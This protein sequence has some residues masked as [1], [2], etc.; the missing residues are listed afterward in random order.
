MYSVAT[1]KNSINAILEVRGLHFNGNNQG[2]ANLDTICTVNAVGLTKVDDVFQPHTTSIIL[3]HLI[4][5]NLGMEHDQSNCD[6]SKGP[7]CIMTNNIPYFTSTTFSGC[8]IQK[9]FKTLNQGY[10]ACLFNM[11]TLRMS[12]CGNSILEEPEECDCGPPEECAKHDPCCDPVTCRLI[13]HAEC[14]SG[15]CCKKCK[16]LSSDHLCRTSEGECDIPEYCDGKNGQCPDDLF[17]KNGA[18]CSGGLGY[19]FQ[20]QCPLLKTQCQNVWGEDAENANAA[21][22]ERLNIL[23]T[24]NGNCGYDN[25]GDIRKCATEDSYCG[26]LQCSE[27]EKE[28]VSKDVLPMDFVVYKMNTD[29]SVHECKTRTF[30]STDLKYGLVKDGTK[31]GYQKLCLNQTCTSIRSIISGK[32]PLEEIHSTCSGHGICTNINTCNCEEGW[33]GHD[34]SIIDEDNQLGNA[35]NDAD[36][37]DS[38]ENELRLNPNLAV[39]VLAGCIFI[40]LVLVVI[41]VLFLFNRNLWTAKSATH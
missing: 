16:L 6:C 23:G 9:Y 24:P 21:C 41:A 28:P 34:C 11:P 19:C 33:K 40:G 29:G 17:K 13:K 3:T 38:M 4:G 1:G 30:S 20:G 18:I 37:Y 12:I 2:I 14:S 39:T 27:G 15:P 8:S 7:P 25:K 10:G 31:C 32:C 22:Y 36:Y 5:H 35:K 26:S